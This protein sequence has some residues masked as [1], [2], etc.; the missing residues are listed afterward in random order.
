MRVVSVKAGCMRAL[1]VCAV[2]YALSGCGAGGSVETVDVQ[3]RASVTGGNVPSEL[4]VKFTP[5]L[6]LQ[7]TVSGGTSNYGQVPVGTVV[8]AS[9]KNVNGASRLGLEILSNGCVRSSNSCFATGCT[10]AA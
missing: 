9:L 1:L 2:T 7:P 6:T 8:E 4:T 5:T 10:A 3:V